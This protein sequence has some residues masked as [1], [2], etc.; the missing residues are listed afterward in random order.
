MT[1]TPSEIGPLVLERV[2][3]A[4]PSTAN[5]DVIARLILD[6][7]ADSSVCFMAGGSLAH[8]AKPN[9]AP[10]P[11]RRDRQESLYDEAVWRSHGRVAELLVRNGARRLRRRRTRGS[12]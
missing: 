5:A 3:R 2:R 4:N 6:N 1:R 8:G 9:S 11:E 10:G 7:G 12:R